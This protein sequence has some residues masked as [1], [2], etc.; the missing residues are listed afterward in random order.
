MMDCRVLDE[1]NFHTLVAVISGFLENVFYKFLLSTPEQFG[2]CS[3]MLE[4]SKIMLILKIKQFLTVLIL[5]IKQLFK[6]C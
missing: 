4:L 2:V 5:K 1:L 6:V 3:S